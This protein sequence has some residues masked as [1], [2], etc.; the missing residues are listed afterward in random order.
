MTA[1]SIDRIE[2]RIARD[3][4]RHGLYVAPIAMLGVGLWR[5]PDAAGAVALAFALIIGNFLLSAAILGWTARV[6][7]DLLMGAALFSFLGRLILITL[8]GVG[9]KELDIVDWPVFC[10]TLVVSYL[11]LLF[12]ELRS[13]SVSLASP[14]L[15]PSKTRDWE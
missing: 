9:I 13:I 1:V 3:V 4:A 10:I 8:L 6:H 5:G 12:W 15:K 14:G 11:G 7:P 2:S